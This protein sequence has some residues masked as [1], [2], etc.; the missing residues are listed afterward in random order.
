VIEEV[1]SGKI[2]FQDSGKV[3]KLVEHEEPIYEGYRESDLPIFRR[4][5][6]LASIIREQEPQPDI[7]LFGKDFSEFGELFKP[8]EANPAIIS[9]FLGS[10]RK[11]ESCTEI[12]E[13]I[14]VGEWR[15][16]S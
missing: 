3:K 16:E 10:N 12:E 1:S 15:R 9:K 11:H 13:S 2:G 4:V 8:E 7:V 14:I 5:N 6:V